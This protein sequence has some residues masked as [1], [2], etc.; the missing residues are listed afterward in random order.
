MQYPNIYNLDKGKWRFFSSK[1]NKKYGNSIELEHSKTDSVGISYQI[2]KDTDDT[3]H[4]VGYEE[5][6]EG[7]MIFDFKKVK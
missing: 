1:Y 2:Q 4:I 6:E 3:L 5:N 7:F